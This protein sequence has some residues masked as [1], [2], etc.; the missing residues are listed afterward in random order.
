MQAFEVVPYGPSVLFVGGEVDMATAPELERA[1]AECIGRGG[2]VVVD[3]SAVSFIDSTAIRTLAGA[4][5]KLRSG[6][7]IVHGV[8]G[9]VA[10]VLELVRFSDLPKAHL[11]PCIGDPY[12]DGSP[13]L[14]SLRA[15]FQRL[16]AT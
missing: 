7:L 1:L 11:L 4:A 2:P 13:R 12:P 15:T 3:L 10:K 16:R 8:Q 6:C 5:D 14:Q 9:H